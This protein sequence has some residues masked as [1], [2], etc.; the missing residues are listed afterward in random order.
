MLHISFQNKS[1]A[2]TPA[3]QRQ[4]QKDTR[5]EMAIKTRNQKEGKNSSK[6]GLRG[7]GGRVFAMQASELKKLKGCYN[8][9]TEQSETQTKNEA[10]CD[11]TTGC[12]GRDSQ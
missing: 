8:D 5:T 10:A 7:D 6:E 4:V 2:H 9:E 3:T 12:G 1:G 11:I